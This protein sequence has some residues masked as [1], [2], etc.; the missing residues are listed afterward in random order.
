MPFD[1]SSGDIA[2]RASPRLPMT[3]PRASR[4]GHTHI[5]EKPKPLARY[6]TDNSQD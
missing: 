5:P 3:I 1:L 4:K 6:D 2:E